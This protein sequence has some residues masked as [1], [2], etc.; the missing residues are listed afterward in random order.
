MDRH[1]TDPFRDR[2]AAGQGDRE[3]PRDS[4]FLTATLRIAENEAQVRVRN[5]SPGGLMAEYARPVSLGEPLQIE[6][7]GI[8]WVEGRIA[9][10]TD[11]RVGIAFTQPIDP[12]RARKPVG[13]GKADDAKGWL[14]VYPAA[15][16]PRL[17]R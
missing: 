1:S 10:A 17:K 12:K 16:P 9:W 13:N 11:G 7:R 4:L 15:T 8:G 5:L 6:V 14:H 2:H 3:R